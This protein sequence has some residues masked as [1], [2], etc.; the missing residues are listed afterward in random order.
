MEDAALCETG[1]TTSATLG[2]A[3]EI[4]LEIDPSEQAMQVAF[5]A[6]LRRVQHSAQSTVAILNPPHAC[7]GG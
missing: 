3:A 6:I 4:D 5:N 2:A 1:G 7:A